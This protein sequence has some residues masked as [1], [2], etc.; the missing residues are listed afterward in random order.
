MGGGILF[1]K[2]E[3]G[4]RGHNRGDMHCGTLNAYICTGTLVFRLS[5]DKRRGGEH[6]LHGP[7]GEAP[8]QDGGEGLPQKEDQHSEEVGS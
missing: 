5:D 4:L 2:R 6:A 3:R 8:P 1:K 7:E